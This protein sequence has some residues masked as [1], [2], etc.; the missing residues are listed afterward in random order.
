MANKKDRKH[1][2]GNSAGGL[3]PSLGMTDKVHLPLGTAKEKFTG[4]DHCSMVLLDAN[5]Y[6]FPLSGPTRHSS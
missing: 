6:G 4:D 2:N 3:H 1:N 5:I